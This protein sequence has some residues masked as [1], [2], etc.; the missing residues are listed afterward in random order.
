VAAT[1]RAVKHLKEKLDA[2]AHVVDNPPE[3]P[4]AEL[5][6]S[7]SEQPTSAASSSTAPPPTET[8]SDGLE[9][10]RW[11]WWKGKRY[12]IPKGTV[13]RLLEFMWNRDS[14]S[15]EALEQNDVF[16]SS[17]LPQ[18]VRSYVN[19]ANTALP[20]GFPW[21]LSSDANARQLT[22]LPITDLAEPSIL[23]N[24]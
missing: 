15:Y 21:R 18:T 19:K 17:V 5:L 4:P 7:S 2:T 8:H 20:S 3:C 22:K 10:G 23:K 16:E 1:E 6:T 12:N 24:P 9:G 11:L 14:A 13:Y